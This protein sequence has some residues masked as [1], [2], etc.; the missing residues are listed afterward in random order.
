ML[1]VVHWLWKN[2]FVRWCVCVFCLRSLNY[3]TATPQVLHLPKRKYLYLSLSYALQ[4]SNATKIDAAFSISLSNSKYCNSI[5]RTTK[6][7]TYKSLFL[8]RWCS[9]CAPVKCTNV[10][11]DERNSIRMCI[12]CEWHSALTY[13]CTI[14]VLFALLLLCQI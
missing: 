14:Q 10:Y 12:V 3:G 5:S 9:L 8:C 6:N 2:L 11:L 7:W 1:F 13:S 4:Q